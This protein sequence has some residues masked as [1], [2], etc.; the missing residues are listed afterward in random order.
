VHQRGVYP[1]QAW[2]RAPVYPVPK[3]RDSPGKRLRP[4]RASPKNIHA[5]NGLRLSGARKR[6]RC[7]RGFGDAGLLAMGT[8]P[9]A[10]KAVA[11]AQPPKT[12]I[13]LKQGDKDTC[14][15]HALRRDASKRS[16]G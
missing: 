12:V 5:P 7:S 13:V 4:V 2:F 16:R 15:I 6:V 14:R 8:K 9:Q 10:R 11:V 1:K 3:A